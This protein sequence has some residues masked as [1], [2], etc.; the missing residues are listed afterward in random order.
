MLFAH[1]RHLMKMEKMKNAEGS[2]AIGM[3]VPDAE[4]SEQE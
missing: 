1:E 3:T 2:E 4:A